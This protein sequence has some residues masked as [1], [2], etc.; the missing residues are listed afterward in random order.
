MTQFL[1]AVKYKTRM[2]TAPLAVQDIKFVA[3]CEGHQLGRNSIAV[4]SL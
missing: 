1:L 3:D 4:Y 2:T